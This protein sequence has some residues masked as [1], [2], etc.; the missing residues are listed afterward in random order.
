MVA[1]R[2]AVVR[3]ER[4]PRWWFIRGGGAQASEQAS[5][6]PTKQENILT[7]YADC[8][9]P[10][11]AGTRGQTV[12]V[13]NPEAHWQR[14]GGTDDADCRPRG[15]AAAAKQAR[16]NTDFTDKSVSHRFYG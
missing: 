8:P 13:C 3:R 11:S 2:E 14:L 4:V 10:V 6:Q 7:D 15:G 9:Y 16:I 12:G 1:A 5:N